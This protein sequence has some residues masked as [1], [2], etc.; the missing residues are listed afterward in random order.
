MTW[1]KGISEG[2]HVGPQ[3]TWARLGLLACP[4]VLWAPG[5]PPL[6]LFAPEIQKYSEKYRV[7]FS[8][9]SENFYFCV[10]FLLHG[11]NR[12]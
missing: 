8:E 2:A 11:E 3:P 5:A 12:K 9:H 4:G 10:I 6:M 1:T 7:K